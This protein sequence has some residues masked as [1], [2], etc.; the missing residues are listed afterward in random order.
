MQ[1]PST[2]R[3]RLEPVVIAGVDCQKQSVAQTILLASG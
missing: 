3:W 1:V 2:R